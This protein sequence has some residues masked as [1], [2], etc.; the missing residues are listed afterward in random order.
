LKIDRCNWKGLNFTQRIE[1]IMTV[2]W[3]LRLKSFELWWDRFLSISFEND[4]DLVIFQSLRKLEFFIK[5]IRMFQIP[6][7]WW[8][9][10]WN[11]QNF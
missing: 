11:L 1:T 6:K 8:S 3:S 2:I 7:R 5:S 9:F 4:C 10:E